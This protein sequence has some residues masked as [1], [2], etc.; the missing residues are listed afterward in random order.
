MTSKEN[1]IIIAERFRGPPQSGNGGRVSGV[2]ANL[3]NSEHSAGVEITVRS[4]T[5]LDQPMST[6]VNP[7]GSAIVHHDSTV[8]ADIKPTHLAMNVMQP[9]SRSEIKRAAPTS[10]SLLKNLNPRFPTGTG[11]HPG[12]FCYG[13]DR[14]KGLGI[15]A[16]PVDDQVAA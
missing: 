1:Q 8:I 2:F 5:P 3:I 7:Q 13:A 4:G 9:P 14:T 11:F 10:Y 16:A 12:C 15:F 6:K